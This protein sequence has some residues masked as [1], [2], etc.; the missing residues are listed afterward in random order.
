MNK[1]IKNESDLHQTVIQY[2]IEGFN[3]S[4]ATCLPLQPKRQR[5]QVW[6]LE[7]QLLSV[8]PMLQ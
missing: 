1:K 8:V 4:K 5:N 6:R 3:S 2:L 7:K